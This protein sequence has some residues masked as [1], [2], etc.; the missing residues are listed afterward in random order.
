MLSQCQLDVCERI[1][2]LI[3]IHTS[4]LHCVLLFCQSDEFGFLFFITIP[5]HIRFLAGTEPWLSRMERGLNPL[6]ISRKCLFEDITK[7]T[8][9]WIDQE[10]QPSSFDAG[11]TIVLCFVSLVWTLKMCTDAEI[12]MDV[13]ISSLLGYVFPFKIDWKWGVR[14]PTASPQKFANEGEHQPI[15]WPIFKST[16]VPL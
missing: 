8:M 15:V 2:K 4:K 10:L 3:P 14:N 16:P 12:A 6:I 9:L 7:L 5:I 11:L 13:W 1:F